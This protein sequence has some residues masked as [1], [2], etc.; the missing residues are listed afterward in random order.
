MAGD[1]PV[2][3]ESCSHHGCTGVRLAV[4]AWCLAHVA[5]ED[6]SGFEAE[7][8]RIGEQGTIDARRVRLSAELLQNILDAAPHEHGRPMLNVA[9]FDEATFLGEARFDGVTFL[10]RAGFKSATFQ[11]R[12]DFLGVTF[13][14]EARFDGVTFEHEARFV[15]AI[16]R[17][18]TR[19]V[20]VWF[21]RGV[22]FFGA[23]F[24]G[25][26]GFDSAIFQGEAGFDRAISQGGLGFV[27]AT[28]QGRVRFLDATFQREVR[29]VGA[30]FQSGAWFNRATFHSEVG[31][32]RAIFQRGAFFYGTSFEH[33]RQIGP[34]IARELDLGGAVFS[35]R[36]QIDVA[37]AALCAQRAQ[38]AAGV[39]F[40]LRW[41]TVILD[42]ANLAAPAI[43]SGVPPFTGVDEQDAAKRWQRLPPG[44]RTQRWRPRLMSLCRADVAGRGSPMWTYGH[45]GSL[46]RTIW[47][48]CGL[49]GSR[50]LP[51]SMAGG[52]RVARRW[53][54]SSTGG[55]TALGTGGQ[56]GGIRRHV[57]RRRPRSSSS[58]SRSPRRSLRRCTASC[59]RVA[60]MPRTSRARPTSTTARWRCADMALV[61]RGQSDSYCGFT[62][63]CQAIAFVGFEH[64][65]CWPSLLSGLPLCCNPLGSMAAILHFGMP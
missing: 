56:V 52:G 31:F 10:D 48:D 49:R 44:P 45:A 51:P 20:E 41:A 33:A 5:E 34:L 2:L 16:F 26:A 42:D 37:A 35:E 4:S 38:F 58:L 29:F 62:G 57:N 6:H 47:T 43:I 28:F 60:R 21:R 50:C 12:A 65:L 39:Q 61:R 11:G 9:Q 23:T 46:A 15:G 63:S 3:R 36:V 40:R 7:L 18:S 64:W 59:A 13:R 1:Q 25:E 17:G 53:P 54:R 14:H 24:Q 19:F 8:K 55:P 32:D 22:R 27:G 30:R